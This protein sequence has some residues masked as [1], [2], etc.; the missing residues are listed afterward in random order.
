VIATS[1]LL[2]FATRLGSLNALEQTRASSAWRSYLGK[3]R[4]PSADTLGRVAAR[5]DLD[6]LRSLTRHIY[7][8][9][10]RNKALLAPRH[11]LIALVLDAHETTASYRRR[12]CPG[13]LQREVKTANGPRTQHYHRLVVASLVGEDFHLFIDAEPIQEGEGEVSAALRLVRRV[14]AH[15]P[16]AFDLVIGD[17][18]YA[19][20]GFFKA[21]IDLGK[22]VLTVIKQEA[23][24]LM[25]D[26]RALFE[27]LPP[28]VVRVDQTEYRIWDEKGFRTWPTLGVPVRVVRTLE[29]KKLRRQIDHR[30]EEVQ[31]EWFWVT[32]LDPAAASTED[33]V[34]IGHSRWTIE[35]R[36]FNEAANH[37]AMDHV[38]RHDP[39]AIVAFWLL[40]MVAYNLVHTFYRRDIKPARRLRQS[41]QTV[42]ELLKAELLHPLA[43]AH[44]PP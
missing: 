40:G 39:V 25:Q 8:R 34:Q 17:S 5:M 14:H 43:C 7:S 30:I 26:A 18:L 28:R 11:G 22:D 10:K 44:A 2:M 16:R 36:G 1:L 15:L 19:E 41:L 31:S 37:W 23:R 29:T 20:A 38:Y 3:H 33:V 9:L 21:V 13:C 32:T 27:A 12:R 4:F 42:V 24:E 35:N 6:E